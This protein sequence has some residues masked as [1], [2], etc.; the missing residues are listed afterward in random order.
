[1]YIYKIYIYNIF[2]IY[3]IDVIYNIYIYKYVYVCLH[4]FVHVCVFMCVHFFDFY[5][6]NFLIVVLHYFNLYKTISQNEEQSL[7][8]SSLDL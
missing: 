5:F 3:I 6:F 2:N 4:V 8:K 7:I 1:M